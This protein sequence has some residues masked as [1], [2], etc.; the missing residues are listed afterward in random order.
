[1]RAALL[2]VLLLTGCGAPG[3]PSGRVRGVVLLTGSVERGAT[4][5]ATR[6]ASCHGAS[7]EG[8]AGPALAPL[9]RVQGVEDLAGTILNGS[10][11]M[12]GQPAMKD[13]EIADVIAWGKATLK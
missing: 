5:F 7:G 4:V 3:D 9:F 11:Q 12:P 13:Q 10:G 2:S 6:C 1:M 8:A